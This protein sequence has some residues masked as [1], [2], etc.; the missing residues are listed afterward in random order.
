MATT[1]KKNVKV[2][3][4]KP[5]KDAKGGSRQKQLNGRSNAGSSTAGATNRRAV[6]GRTVR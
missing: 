3:D 5:S 6:A 1:K 4:M 2:G